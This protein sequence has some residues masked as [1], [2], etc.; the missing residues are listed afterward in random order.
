MF[1]AQFKKNQSQNK[2]VLSTSSLA[3]FLP[4]DTRKE[5]KKTWFKLQTWAVH[6]PDKLLYFKTVQMDNHGCI[7]DPK[8]NL[9]DSSKFLINAIE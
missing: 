4:K 2:R 5:I 6:N 1:L 9:Y 3:I 7:L 8:L